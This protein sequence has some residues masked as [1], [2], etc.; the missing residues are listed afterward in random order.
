MELYTR[1]ARDSSAR[2]IAAYS[3]S[4]GWAT[5]LLS[6]PMRQPVRDIYAMVR[7]ADEIVDGPAREAGADAAAILDGFEA[8]TYAAIR[9]GFSANLTLHAFAQTARKYGIEQDL[10]EPFFASMRADL[11]ETSHTQESFER[12]IYGSAE[13]I[14]LMCLRV[15]TA[16][17]GRT[18]SQ[19]ELEIL[20]AGACALGSA[21]QKV[22]FLRDISADFNR[23]GR[24]YFPGLTPSNFNNVKRDELVADIDAEIAQ[25]AATLALL[26]TGAR[27]AVKAALLLFAALNSAIAKTE[28][29]KLATTRIRVSDLRK[30][31]IVL[32][33][34]G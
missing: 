17:S 33:A 6:P 22:N 18:Y 11:T 3:T 24:S 13:V 25:A 16:E 28:A 14:G 26:P 21:F 30:L 5:K 32:R 29:S 8:E 4:F 7:V 20:D 12:Y 15:F 10:I 9:V 2:V 31:F 1:A 23:L 27:R 34:L 19:A